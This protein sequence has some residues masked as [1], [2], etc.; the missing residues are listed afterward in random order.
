[1]VGSE[2]QAV[3]PEG[4]CRYDDAL[5][6]ENE[7]K[8]LWNPTLLNEDDIFDYL[9]KSS[10]SSHSIVNNSSS[11]G[12]IDILNDETGKPTSPISSVPTADCDINEIQNTASPA[13]ISS[14]LQNSNTQQPS[15]PLSNNH[16]TNVNNIISN[17]LPQGKH[18]RDDEQALY[19]LQQCGHNV[20][21]A[22]RRRR[23]NA[24]SASSANTMSEWSEEECRLFE[25]GLRVYGKDFHS[26]QQLKVRT[27]AVGELVQF[28]YLWKKT[29]RHDVFANKGRLEKKK[30]SLTPGLTDYMDRFLEDNNDQ[31]NC[32]TQPLT[33]DNSLSP[34]FN[35]TLYTENRRHQSLSNDETPTPGINGNGGLDLTIATSTSSNST[36]ST[37][38]TVLIPNNL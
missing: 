1:M 22:L 29:E 19:L 26:I 32:Q 18:L 6:Y 10:T 4:L 15:T 17:V 13:P 7:D 5:P 37:N 35:T 11:G 16:I 12:N 34:G 20:D 28:Y 9:K 36:T 2:F 8:L 25:S 23:I 30:Y 24:I 27:R 33:R 3:I 14:S 21:E 31:M 38:I